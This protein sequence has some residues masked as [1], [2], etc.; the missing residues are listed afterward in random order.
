MRFVVMQK[1]SSKIFDL[2]IRAHFNATYDLRKAQASCHFLEIKLDNFARIPFS[3]RLYS[4]QLQEK[5]CVVS[6]FQV[7]KRIA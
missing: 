5:A 2:S 4:Q 3:S 1:Y 7:S 6:T